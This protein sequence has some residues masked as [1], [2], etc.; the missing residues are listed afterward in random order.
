MAAEFGMALLKV[1]LGLGVFVTLGYLGRFYDKR[2]AGVLLT[3]PILNGIGILA[4]PDPQAVADLIYAVVVFNGMLLF[5]MI[6]F[7]DALT[8]WPSASPTARLAARLAVWTAIWAVGAPLVI[9]WRDWLPGAFGLLAIQLAVTAVAVPLIWKA[10]RHAAQGRPPG[11]RGAEHVRAFVALWHNPAGLLR[12]GLFVA[13]CVLLLAVAHFY[14]TYWVG[15]VSAL[16]LPGLF[17]IA[18]LSVTEERNDFDLLRDSILLGPP[19]VIAF[20]WLFAQTVAQL[21]AEAVARAAFG[22][23]AFVLMLAADALLIFWI[24]P[25]ISDYLD[26]M[27][28]QGTR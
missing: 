22:I 28:R 2:V 21:P 12:I 15:L 11:P 1:L 14:S 26:R 8:P 27:R 7:C 10:P 16:P 6:S 17:A 23:P 4:G 20:N 9:A 25:K 18:M 3:F 13:C 24:V 5:L 19:L